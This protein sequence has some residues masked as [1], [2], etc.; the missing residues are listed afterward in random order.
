MGG[1]SRHQSMYGERADLYDRIYHFKDYAA[2]TARLRAML[3][4]AGVPDGA[5][6][7]EAACGTGNYLL[8]LS[9][10]YAVEGFDLNPAM[11]ARARR[12][13]PGAV[14]READ[15]RDFALDAPADVL[16]CLFSSFGY[17]EPERIPDAAACFFRAV[18]PGGLAV[19]EPWITPDESKPGHTVVQTYDGTT[20]KPPEAMRVVRAVT[21]LP[22]GR[23]S[24]FDFHWLVV[25]PA[26]VEH[27]VDHHELWQ[28]TPDELLAAFRGAGFDAT[29]IHPGPLTGRGT[30]WLRRPA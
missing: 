26:G 24:V 30:L 21:H 17:V 1:T 18:R 28:S 25:T 3:L 23:R 10:H 16:L 6:V 22:E 27:I 2:E 14:V 5:R 11:A 19:V 12:K 15:M 20:A 7:V 8:P 13:V 4:A 29:W 9:R